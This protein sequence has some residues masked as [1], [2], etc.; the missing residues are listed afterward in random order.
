MIQNRLH[1]L[2]SSA[3]SKRGVP[4]TMI[5]LLKSCLDATGHYVELRYH[6]RTS[7][8]FTV[9]KH[10]VDVANHSVVEGIGVR[11][12]ANGV[13][14]FAATHLCE[15][16]SVQQA[17]EAA[18]KHAQI[19]GRNRP[20]KKSSPIRLA[21][22]S[23]ATVQYEGPGYAELRNMPIGEK[24]SHIIDLEKNLSTK[25]RY[26]KSAK[27]RY[28]EILEEKTIVTSDGAAAS[29]K[30][31]QPEVRMVAFAEKKGEQNAASS[32]AGVSGGWDCLYRHPALENALEHTAQMAVDQ[33]DAK[34]ANAGPALCILAPDIVGL[35]CHEAI[36]HTVE[37][38]FVK[39]G[40]VAQGKIGHPIGSSLV[41][42]ADT[43]CETIS[44]YAVGN[45]PFDD[46]GVLTETT[47][48][49]ENGILKSYLHN[50][51]TAEE[52]GVKPTGNARA[53]LY[54][55]EP[56]IRMRNTYF[57]P[58]QQDLAQMIS[59]V[60]DGYLLAGGGS[61]QAD[62]NG[63]FMFGASEVWRIKNGKKH[64]LLK[65]AT[66]SG[67][68]FDVLHTVDAVSKEFRWDL[69]TGYCGKGQYAK[70]DAGGPYVRCKI[71]L[72]GRLD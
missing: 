26:V 28:K 19:L 72:G 55:D 58:G 7:E 61:G 37:A 53:W 13:W 12:L 35:L 69:G 30:L 45:M 15:K 23:L 54:D 41:H 34:Y 59:E 11:V 44:G 6:R 60:D 67:I 42:M 16:A 3:H 66:L 57:L 21:D 17:I 33:L 1:F 18:R 39:A 8:S 29:L 62:A 52:F 48:I 14:G 56:I 70:V 71:H 38:D 47:T 50:R 27:C 2:D 63:E 40:S 49:I 64:Q 65:E 43:G 20:L 10:R 46:E 24:L 32:G 9:Q 68:A 4:F 5:E 51:E 25:T 22:A 31:A 36:G